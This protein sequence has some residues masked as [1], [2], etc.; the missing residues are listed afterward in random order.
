M[1][2][3]IVLIG[4]TGKDPEVKDINGT[5]LAKI[6]LA[7]SERY[8][9]KSGEMVDETQWHNLVFWGAQ[10]G[11]VEQYVRKG[12]LISVTGKV[13]YNSYERDGEKKYF[14]EVKCDKL[15]LMPKVS[16]VPKKESTD[17]IDGMPF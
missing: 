10:A 17:D 7:T 6:S 15:I 2:N 9:T 5:K 11:F 16:D 3:H 4:N 1:Y 8:K 12:Q 14:T 13:I